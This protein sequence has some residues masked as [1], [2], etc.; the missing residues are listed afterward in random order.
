MKEERRL[1]RQCLLSEPGCRPLLSLGQGFQFVLE[2]FLAYFSQQFAELSTGLHTHGNQVVA[3][4][5]RRANLG[6]LFE[7]FGLLNKKIVN[8]QP[9]MGTNTIEAMKLEF[10]RESRAH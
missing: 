3:V 4:K 2:L 6:L 8:V 5:K 10:E 1:G 7:L 9:A